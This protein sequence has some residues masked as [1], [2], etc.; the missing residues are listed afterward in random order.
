MVGGVI[1]VA[2]A[3]GVGELV[4]GVGAGLLDCFGFGVDV[5]AGV[6]AGAAAGL[7]VSELE[8]GLE[9]N[10]QALLYCSLFGTGVKVM[11]TVLVTLPKLN[12]WL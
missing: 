3:V 11:T 2:L 9:P 12:V 7:M 5:G 4:A 6:G 1:V 10:G 8:A